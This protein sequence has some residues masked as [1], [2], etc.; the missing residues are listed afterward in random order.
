VGKGTIIGLNHQHYL[1]LL[2]L[3][4]LPH[5]PLSADICCMI[6]LK[7]GAAQFS[8]KYRYLLVAVLLLVVFSLFPSAVERYYSQGF[9]PFFSVILRTIFG[10]FPVSLGDLIYSGGIIYLIFSIA[11][12]LYHRFVRKR[13]SDTGLLLQKMVVAGL[14]LYVIFKVFWGLNYDRPTVGESRQLGNPEYSLE[15]LIDFNDRLIEALNVNRSVIP[16]DTL[17]SITFSQVVQ[18]SKQAYASLAESFPEIAW[19][20]PALKKSLLAELGDW[21]GYTGYYNP[22]TGEAQIRTELPDILLPY[23]A[24]HEV[25][26][27]L[28]Y[29]RESEASYIGWLAAQAQEDARLRYSAALDLYDQ[30]QQEL[31]RIYALR[32]DSAGLR[33]Q[34]QENARRLDT[35]VKRDRKAIRQFF[36]TRTHAV[37]P[38]FN[39]LYAQYLRMN[40]QK[41]GMR[42]YREVVGWILA[43]ERSRGRKT[44]LY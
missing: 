9:Y 1:N 40:G 43:E 20:A 11:R 18:I 7:R 8:R 30:V 41:E 28:G 33:R 14:W 39:E 6:S 27:Q 44:K 36:R 42:S 38:A 26:H 37:T 25:A 17:P 31:W 29:A 5:S 10:L 32:G 2:I 34:L 21:V 15:E 23:I 19:R 13:K 3:L 24:C 16:G 4:R 12:W 35:S 22:F